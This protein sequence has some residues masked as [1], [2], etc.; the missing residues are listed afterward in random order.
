MKGSGP[1]LEGITR[2]GIEL[3][4]RRPSLPALPQPFFTGGIS[5][6]PTRVS[7][8]ASNDLNPNMG[9]VTRFTSMIR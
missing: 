7:W 8:A 5:S 4:Q 9:R 1:G 2:P 6:I 3:S